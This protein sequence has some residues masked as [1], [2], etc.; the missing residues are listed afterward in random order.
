MYYAKWRDG[1]GRQVK[2]HLRP[3]W[4]VPDGTG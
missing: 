4:L 2:R 3:A 1:T